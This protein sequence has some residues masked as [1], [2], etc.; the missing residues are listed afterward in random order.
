MD[1]YIREHRVA[2]VKAAGEVS[3]LLHPRAWAGKQRGADVKLR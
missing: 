2:D 1:Y 3:E